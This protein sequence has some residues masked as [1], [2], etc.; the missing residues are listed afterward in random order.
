MRKLIAVL[1]VVAWAGFWA[2]G[3]LAVSSGAGT[4]PGQMVIAALLAAGGG[5]LGLWAWLTLIRLGGEWGQA[6]PL[7]ATRTEGETA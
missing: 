7:R 4:A 3:Y 2:F 5:A 1:N 6:R